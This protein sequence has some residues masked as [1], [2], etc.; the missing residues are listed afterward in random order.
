MGCRNGSTLVAR[1]A[2]AGSADADP[3]VQTRTHVLGNPTMDFGSSQPVIY[4]TTPRQL[5]LDHLAVMALTPA[6]AEPATTQTLRI[7]GANAISVTWRGRQDVI[8]RR[9]AAARQVIGRVRTDAEIAKLTEGAGETIIRG[10]TRLSSGARAYISV[11]GTAATVTVSGD[12]VQAFGDSDNTYRVFAPQKISSVLV[13][14]AP[15]QTCR[16]GNYLRL[17]C[18]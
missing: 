1:T 10:G 13:N 9:L 11:S 14:G 17:P 2:A 16:D 8:V 6:G 18:S 5:A 3:V 7:P 15:V 4:T 12:E